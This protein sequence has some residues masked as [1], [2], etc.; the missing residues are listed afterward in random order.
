MCFDFLY[1]SCLQHFSFWE[2]M[3]EMWSKMY[4]DLHV[5]YPLFLSDINGSWIFATDF[6]K[7]LKYQIWWKTVQWEASCSMWT[8]GRT[9]N[10]LSTIIHVTDIICIIHAVSL[11]ISWGS[12]K[13]WPRNTKGIYKD[14]TERETISWNEQ[15]ALAWC[16]SV[17]GTEMLHASCG[18]TWE[19]IAASTLPAVL[20][21]RFD[22]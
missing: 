21:R 13:K 8:D 2:E 3:S 20:L 18:N 16:N 14:F 15:H 22:E 12:A 1:N 17:E 7:I 19:L 10:H 11:H 5:K 6:R 4:I 9:K